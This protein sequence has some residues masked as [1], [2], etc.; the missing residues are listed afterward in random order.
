MMPMPSLGP[1]RRAASGAGL[2]AAMDYWRRAP[3]SARPSAGYKEWSHFSIMGDIM[4][5][6]LDLLMNFSLMEYPRDGDLQPAPRPRREVGHLT[7]LYRDAAGRWAGE[8]ERY[9]EAAVSVQGGQPDIALGAN[10][11]RIADGMYR[12]RLDLPSG[13]A[14][15]E[16]DLVPVARPV[17][18]NRVPLAGAEY[19]RWL[20][21]PR[22]SA[23]GEVRLGGRSFLLDGAPAYHDRNWGQFTWGGSCAWE[24]AT[25]LPADP[26]TPWTLVYSRIS[27]G[28]RAETLSQSLILWRDALPHRKFFGRDLRV[29]Q[30][31]GLSGCR[32]VQIP[33]VMALLSAGIGADLPREMRVRAAAFRD[34]LRLEIE[35]ADFAQ[36]GIP[37]DGRWGVSKL[38]EARGRVQVSGSVGGER[39]RFDGR[40]HAEF[41][42]PGT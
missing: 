26:E 40:I 7:L 25:I 21:V 35:L 14:R 42:Q 33:K 1:S 30:R 41:N 29:E 22:L 8:V 10:T 18:A 3:T 36:I 32:P 19:I 37:N 2:F 11:A 15:G 16:I 28:L 38:S 13:D 34:E 4:G 9:N 20:V 5:D 12:V 24:W 17:F 6:E 23:S 31:G 39:V 27:D